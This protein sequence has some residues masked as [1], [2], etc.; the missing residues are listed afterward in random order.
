MTVFLTVEDLGVGPIGDVGLHESAAARP[1]TSL[2][3]SDA[4]PTLESKAAALLDSLVN[5]R[6]LVDGN[7]QL[8]W[9][10]TVVFSDLNGWRPRPTTHTTS[11]SPWRVVGLL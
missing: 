5:N 10:A 7:K 3:G 9:L 6:A 8:G 11:S 2:W 4:Y 1:R